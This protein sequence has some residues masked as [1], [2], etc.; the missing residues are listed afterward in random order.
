MMCRS[1]A[2]LPVPIIAKAACW[3]TSARFAPLTLGS[4]GSGGTGVKLDSVKRWR[5]PLDARCITPEAWQCSPRQRKV[6]DDANPHTSSR[7]NS[8]LGNR[9]RSRRCGVEN[10]LI[11]CGTMSAADMLPVSWSRKSANSPRICVTRLSEQRRHTVWRSMASFSF[12]KST[13]RRP[14]PV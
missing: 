2:E 12:S 5:F 14:L 4:P 3:L 9:S 10:D 7:T 13:S 11:K 8:W 6:S 1:R